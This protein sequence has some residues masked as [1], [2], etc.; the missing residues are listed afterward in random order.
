MDQNN[1]MDQYS[2]N[3]TVTV[4]GHGRASQAPDVLTLN[5][6]VEVSRRTLVGAYQDAARSMQAVQQ[7]LA[8]ADVERKDSAT[9]G[10]SLRSET[11]WQEDK[12]NV[13]TGYT[14]SS[15]LTVRMGFK[16]GA[17]DSAQQVIAKIVEAGGNDVRLNGLQPEISDPGEV[18]EQARTLA[19]ADAARNANHFAELAGRKL[20]RVLAIS[21]G[22][23]TGSGPVPMRRMSYAA[24]VAM[25]IEAGES[26]VG[27]SVTA[28]WELV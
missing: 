16:D 22:Q 27:A 14:C 6:S 3:N 8:A 17:S 11:V 5:I 4:T 15:T 18:A 9:S 21:E 1:P 10:L 23:D 20:G 12:G 24:E 2:P 26:S 19:W 25:P 28:T 13:V 7:A